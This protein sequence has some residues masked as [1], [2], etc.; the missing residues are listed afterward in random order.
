MGRRQHTV[1]AKFLSNWSDETKGR[2]SKVWMV[3]EKVEVNISVENVCHIKNFYSTNPDRDAEMSG[4]ESNFCDLTDQLNIAQPTVIDSYKKR[5][6]LVLYICHL[7]WR[8]SGFRNHTKLERLDLFDHWLGSYFRVVFM[9]GSTGDTNL[10]EFGKSLLNHLS[11]S[12][13]VATIE[14]NI[15]ELIIG[16]DPVLSF[17]QDDKYVAFLLP[18]SPVRLLAIINSNYFKVT[19]YSLDTKSAANINGMTAAKARM[20]VFMKSKPSA[21]DSKHIRNILKQHN[22]VSEYQDEVMKTSDFTSQ[23]LANLCIVKKT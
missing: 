1:P 18:I 17:R 5:G 2:K 20:F 21:D 7:F 10:Q 19:C 22:M 14:S 13:T 6:L 8:G 16:D 9:D 12:W 11:A 3:G 23:S 15:D 4:I